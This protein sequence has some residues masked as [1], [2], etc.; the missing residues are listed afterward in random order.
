MQNENER[1]TKYK[2]SSVVSVF[3]ELG[4]FVEAC[5]RLRNTHTQ[6]Y[7][8]HRE[9]FKMSEDR[10]AYKS[11]S[12]RLHVVVSAGKIPSPISRFDLTLAN[13][14]YTTRVPTTNTT[15]M[16]ITIYNAI[17]H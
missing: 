7:T 13:E 9:I 10:Y 6:T 16:N 5:N 4:D 3:I 1:N 11:L 12:H 15:I 2:T 8:S 17:G 14:Q